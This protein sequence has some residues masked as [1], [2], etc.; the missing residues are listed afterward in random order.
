M[1]WV[2][3][4]C[5]MWK[6]RYEDLFNCLSNSKDVRTICKN[7]EIQGDVEVSYSEII[8]VIKYLKDNKN[9]GLDDISAEHLKHC[10]DVIIPMLSVCFISLFV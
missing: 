3:Q 9:C 10:S 1:N 6:S 7:A 8:S 4:H 2:T 5:K